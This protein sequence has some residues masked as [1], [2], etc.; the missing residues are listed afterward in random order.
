MPTTEWEAIERM[1]DIDTWYNWSW[2][3]SGRRQL[4]RRNRQKSIG[5]VTTSAVDFFESCQELRNFEINSREL[6]NVYESAQIKTR[7]TTTNLYVG[8]SAV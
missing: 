2:S 5:T 7:L 4:K 3:V 8:C 1:A 6:Q